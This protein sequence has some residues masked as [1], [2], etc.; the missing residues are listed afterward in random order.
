MKGGVGG[1]GGGQPPG[2][3]AQQVAAA[4]GAAGL[5]ACGLVQQQGPAAQDRETGPQHL[6]VQR[7]RQGHG[8]APPVLGNA[9]QSGLFQG[10]HHLR[11]G[12]VFGV[13]Q[14]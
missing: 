12:Q 3:D 1:A 7:M 4:A 10:G 13:G 11:R 6:A 2:G 5:D 8:G 9:D 14:G